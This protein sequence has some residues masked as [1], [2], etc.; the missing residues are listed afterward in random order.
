MSYIMVDGESD[1]PIPGD[2]SLVCFGAVVVR[3]GLADSFYG[4]LR[5]ISEKREP[6]ALAVSGFTREETLAFDDPAKVMHEFGN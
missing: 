5:P 6:G 1:G 4:R 2:F 3:D